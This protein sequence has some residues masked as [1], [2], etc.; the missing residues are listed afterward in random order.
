MVNDY[1]VF[2]TSHTLGDGA[3]ELGEKLMSNYMI[4][5]SEGQNLP[6]HIF[7]MNSGVQL[8]QEG[9][10]VLGAL[11]K[12]AEAGVK[13]LACG[14]CLDYYQLKEKLAVGEISNI[15]TLRDLFA[16]ASKVIS[17]G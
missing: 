10:K 2:V 4:A 12:L 14:T 11:E 17:L 5:L 13:I 15:Y 16:S 9:S 7:F 3:E 6:A 8:V 1:L